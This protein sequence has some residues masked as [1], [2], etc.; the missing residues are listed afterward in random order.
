MSSSRRSIVVVIRLFEATDPQSSN[1]SERP[2]AARSAA[3]APPARAAA[4]APRVSRC[5]D[6]R[7][8]CAFDGSI[9]AEL[10]N[11]E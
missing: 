8:L 4:E 7:V 9:V 1:G 11:H 6:M 5:S 2:S 3:E 10:R